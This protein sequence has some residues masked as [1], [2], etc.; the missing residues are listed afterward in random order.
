[1]GKVNAVTFQAHNDKARVFTLAELAAVSRLVDH[2]TGVA[3]AW[4]KQPPTAFIFFDT[5]EAALNAAPII[6]SEILES[7]G[8][9]AVA[10][11]TTFG[12]STVEQS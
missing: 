12:E 8:I 10:I 3:L 11:R 1:M 7:M 9:A 4:H 6:A 5:M 2:C